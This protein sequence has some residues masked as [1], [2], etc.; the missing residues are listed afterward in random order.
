M[1]NFRKKILNEQLE[2]VNEELEEKKQELK[3]VTDI[4]DDISN[5]ETLTNCHFENNFMSFVILLFALILGSFSILA[6]VYNSIGI[7]IVTGLISVALLGFSYYSYKFILEQRKEIKKLKKKGV[8]KQKKKQGE[9][10]TKKEVLEKEYD[11]IEN[12]KNDIKEELGCIAY[13]DMTSNDLLYQV[14]FE[15]EY[16]MRNK[17]VQEYLKLLDDF[18]NEK[19]DYSKVQFNRAIEDEVKLEKT[20]K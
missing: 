3:G 12:K 10:L 13:Y 17:D 5:Y 19:V 18:L 6:I 9:L 15:E 8:K 14:D 4:L 16:E 7:A 20:Y 11:S 1:Y 2:K